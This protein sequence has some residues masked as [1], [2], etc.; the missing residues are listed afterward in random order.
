MSR[1]RRGI[2]RRQSPA[3]SWRVPASR[4]SRISALT[5]SFQRWD[6]VS[7]ARCTTA[8][9]P[10]SASAGAG[11]GGPV[12]RDGVDA[13]LLAR[14][15]GAARQRRDLVAARLQRRDEPRADVAGRAGDG[16]PHAGP[17]ARGRR[18]DAS[19]AGS[20]TSPARRR[21]SELARSAG[22]LAYRGAASVPLASRRTARRGSLGASGG[23]RATVTGTRAVS[24]RMDAGDPAS[25]PGASVMPPIR[26]RTTRT[27]VRRARSPRRR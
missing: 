22:C 10:A 1:R 21:L 4:L 24:R 19:G 12:P 27:T 5:A 16:H 26:P 8:S 6:T 14:A 2:G 13:E 7:P 20:H 25:D 3:T 9:R 11:P 23:S 18:S 17:C 15:S